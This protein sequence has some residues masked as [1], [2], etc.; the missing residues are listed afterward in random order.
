M[1]RK[2]APRRTR[3]RF[4]GVNPNTGNYERADVLSYG[5]DQAAELLIAEKGWTKVSLWP[6]G[7]RYQI[8]MRAL[9]AACD[10]FDLRWQV[11]IRYRPTTLDHDGVYRFFPGMHRV[12]L[13]YEH[14]YTVHPTLGVQ[15]DQAA[16]LERS[17]KTLWHELQHCEQGERYGL[18]YG[19]HI[20]GEKS[21]PYALRP[22]EIEATQAEQLHFEVGALT[23]PR[24]L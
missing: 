8:D 14:G 10:Y 19:Q 18:A 13:T 7:R 6:P 4:V 21:I 22:S 12:T 1:A 5:K 2:R 3:H 17:S 9:R 24:R 11:E 23:K 20:D 16:A 15:F